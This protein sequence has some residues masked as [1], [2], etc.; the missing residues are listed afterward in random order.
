MAFSSIGK[1]YFR[2]EQDEASFLW[3]YSI[4]VVKLLWGFCLLNCGFLKDSNDIAG[5]F[6]AKLV[7]SVLENGATDKICR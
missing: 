6:C 4:L 5:S 2:Q 7:F 1:R 3:L